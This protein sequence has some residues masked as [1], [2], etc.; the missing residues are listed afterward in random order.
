MTSNEQEL[1]NMI[2]GS[3]QPEQALLTAISIISDYISQN[4]G[5]GVPLDFCEQ[6]PITY[7]PVRP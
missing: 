2:R 1:I 7:R 3:E 6:T 5:K 4:C